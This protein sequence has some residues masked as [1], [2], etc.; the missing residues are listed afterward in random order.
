MEEPKRNPGRPPSGKKPY[1]IRM[2]PITHKRLLEMVNADGFDCIGDWLESFWAESNDQAKPDN[3]ATPG[4]G[5]DSAG[6]SG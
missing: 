6:E 3:K 4:T 5:Q 1:C 2:L